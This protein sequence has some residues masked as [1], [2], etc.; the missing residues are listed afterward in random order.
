MNRPTKIHPNGASNIHVEYL[1]PKTLTGDVIMVY[2]D[3]NIEH[4]SVS[5]HEIGRFNAG[6]YD[7]MP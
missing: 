6:H 3:C 7:E 4:H 2:G 1:S 5:H